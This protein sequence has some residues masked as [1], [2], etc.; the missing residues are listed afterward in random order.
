MTKLRMLF[1]IIFFANISF[2]QIRLPKDGD[3]IISGYAKKMEGV[4]QSEDQRYI[5]HIAPTTT[6]Q[7]MGK[8]RYTTEAIEVE[9]LKLPYKG[10][11][12]STQF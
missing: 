10:Q 2:A 5:L 9:F 7:Q 8:L 12:L 6:F 4:W 11:E 1:I 3:H